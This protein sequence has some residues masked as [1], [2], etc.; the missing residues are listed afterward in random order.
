MT[1]RPEGTPEASPDEPEAPT[2]IESETGAP[3]AVAAATEELETASGALDPE[4]DA[5]E[6]DEI[7]AELEAEDEA[8]E[9]DAEWGELE[10]EDEADELDAESGSAVA[11]AGVAAIGS[12]ISRR[13]EAPTPSVQRAPT[14]SELAVRVTDNASRFFV[15]GTVV[16]F[17]AILAFGLLAGTGGFLTAAPSPT[18][19]PSVS[20]EPS[21]SAGASAESAEPSESAEASASPS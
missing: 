9:L 8:D 13:R 4:S 1:E 10:A 18:A 2:T 7:E 16:V 5:A 21:A 6:I 20:A 17:V 14:Q 11:A 19:V 15:I 3:E 12:A